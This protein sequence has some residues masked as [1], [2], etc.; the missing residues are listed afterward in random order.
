MGK[1]LLVCKRKGK[2]KAKSSSG[3]RS[4]A[5]QALEVEEERGKGE[6]LEERGGGDGN[7]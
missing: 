7:H 3:I 1:E 4:L 2:R 6:I 5:W